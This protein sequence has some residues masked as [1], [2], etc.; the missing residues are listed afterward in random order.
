MQK[1]LILSVIILL[2]LSLKAQPPSP[3]G[4]PNNIANGW[5]KYPGYLQVGNLS[6]DLK[7][8][9]GSKPTGPTLR[10]WQHVGVDSSIWL[11]NGTNWGKLKGEGGSGGGGSTRISFDTTIT[12][13]LGET[14]L[15][16]PHNLL[17]RPNSVLVDIDQSIGSQFDVEWD[18]ANIY[19]KYW[20]GWAGTYTYS[21]K[22][23]P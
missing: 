19:I 10:Y 7:D 22:I 20:V 13:G 14:E 9:S 16:I 1:I 17:S 4:L 2:S 6:F 15:T 18:A 8:T 23:D 3:T 5:Y 11:W 21:I 12:L